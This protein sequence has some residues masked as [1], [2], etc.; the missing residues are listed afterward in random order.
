MG[1]NGGVGVQSPNQQSALLPDAMLHNSM[2][3]QRY[4]SAAFELKHPN[5][6]LLL[7][8]VINYVFFIKKGFPSQWMNRYLSLYWIWWGDVCV[9]C[10]LLLDLIF[11]SS[12][13]MN[14]GVG[15]LGSMPTAT[16]PSTG[17]MRKSW[18]EDI[19]QDLRNHL[20][21]K[22]WVCRQLLW[23]LIMRTS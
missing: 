21:H 8:F 13:L 18:H 19:T 23:N 17:G 20:V 22:L 12:S 4:R 9:F 1:V 3:A 6:S 10:P 2:N 7:L 15:N 16:P 11:P 5:C 14:D